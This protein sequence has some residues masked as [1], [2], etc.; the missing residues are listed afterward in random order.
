MDWEN[1]RSLIKPCYGSD[2]WCSEISC[3]RLLTNKTEKLPHA[4]AA[5]CSSPE[6]YEE[7]RKECW[8][9]QCTMFLLWPMNIC[10]MFGSVF[11]LLLEFSPQIRFLTFCSDFSVSSTSQ[12]MARCKFYSQMAIDCENCSV[13]FL[14]LIYIRLVWASFLF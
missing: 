4:G 7:K 1:S 9:W 3:R 6:S 12:C 8:G 10:L 11:P 2:L 5:A 13:Y 14:W